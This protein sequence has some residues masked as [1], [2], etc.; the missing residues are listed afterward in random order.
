MNKTLIIAEAGVNHNGSLDMALELIDAAFLSG[1]DVV[2]FQTFKSDKTISKYAGKADYQTKSTPSGESQ[3][4]MVKK[5]EFDERQHA[6]LLRH[7]QS[8]GIEFMSSPFD[9]ESIDFLVDS[10]NV[11]CLKIPS[12][13]ITNAPLLLKAAQTG[14]PVILSTG[15]CTLGEVERALGV[16]A[17]GYLYAACS[18]SVDGFKA[19]YCSPEGQQSLQNR[20]ILL[21]CTS[22][23]PAPINEVNLKVMDTLRNAFLLPVG[24]SDHTPGIT[25]PIAAAARGAVV[26]EKHFTLSRGLPGPD[27]K[28]SLEPS[29][30][31][32]MVE[33][34]REV[35]LVL[36][37]A[38]KH[39]TG[40]EIK[41]IKIS[42]K[43]LVANKALAKGEAFTVAN[44]GV[45]RPGTGVDP[46]RYWE[47]L[48]QTA[49]RDYS[50]DEEIE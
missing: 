39:P 22:E 43:S 3:L 26:V 38:Y 13:E 9:L 27:H 1:A 5:L 33:A 19:A 36:G 30:L 10:L 14:K 47:Y 32:K 21:H 24:Y 16:L 20:V 11:R 4:D 50:P 46:F 37:S 25:V 2:K 31:R 35:E 8:K 34:I 17:F 7:C 48:G 23:Y 12:G 40:S 6:T 49:G 18:P 15:M 41:N 42:R 44:L 29:E 28:A 45:K